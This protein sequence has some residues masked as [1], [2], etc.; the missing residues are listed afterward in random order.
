MTGGKAATAVAHSVC[1]LVSVLQVCGMEGIKLVLTL[2][3]QK[4][5]NRYMKARK[6]K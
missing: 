1:K 2:L 5:S 3:S 6:S 4:D